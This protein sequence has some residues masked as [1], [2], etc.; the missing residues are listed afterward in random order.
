MSEKLTRFFS[1]KVLFLLLLSVTAVASP[2]FEKGTLIR[3]AEIEEILHQFSDPLFKAYGLDPS[4]TKLRVIVDP[5]LNA[6]ATMGQAVYLH[7]GLIIKSKSAG[8]LI[9]V[10]AHEGGH[11]ADGHIARTFDAMGRSQ[12]AAI[13]GMILG[14]AGALAGYPEVAAAAMM[15]GMHVAERS[16]LAYSRVQE[17]AADQAALRVLKILK[18]PSSGF[19]G[20]METLEKQSLWPEKQQD[21]Y[22]QTHPLTK[23][24]VSTLRVHAQRTAH[25]GYR[26]P[27]EF[28]AAHRRLVAKLVGFL[29]PFY[30]V[31]RRYPTHDMTVSAR[32]AHAIAYFRNNQPEDALKILDQLIREE[33]QN[34]YFCE[35]KGQILFENGRV[36]EAIPFYERALALCPQSEL[37]YIILAHALIEADRPAYNRRALDLLHQV[38]LKNKEDPLVYQ[39]LALVYGRLGKI[40]EMAL[41]LAEQ[42]YLLG[43]EA[44]MKSQAHRALRHLSKHDRAARLRA[45]DL[46]L[47]ENR[48][49]S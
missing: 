11:I 7:S 18:W 17:S 48:R 24:R 15:G 34:A 33:P 30:E 6:F 32:Y 13:T 19:L 26:L 44:R 35:L 5:E 41:M 36:L 31:F 47:L 27:L 22:R 3:D 9:G 40:G 12:G 10:L 38:L 49:E 45:Q 25:A 16:F 37:F 2:P 20:F 1:F 43:D 8:E 14:A 42:S 39:L 28:E 46:L 4:H 21:A 29:E 23:D